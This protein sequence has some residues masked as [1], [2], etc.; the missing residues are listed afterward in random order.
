MTT[1]RG[2]R[3][4]A[5]WEKLK[6]LLPPHKAHTGRPAKDHRR[7]ING[8]LWT[9]RT[10]GH[11][12]MTYPLAMVYKVEFPVASTAGGHLNTLSLAH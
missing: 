11:H 5:Q 10:W 6:P 12:G 1:H 2:D 8:I 4:D 7:M 9:Q 3:S